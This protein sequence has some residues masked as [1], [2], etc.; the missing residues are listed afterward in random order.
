MVVFAMIIPN[1][2]FLFLFSRDIC[3]EVF[4]SDQFL[5]LKVFN[6]GFLHQFKDWIGGKNG[7]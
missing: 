2:C 4:T 6:V 3:Q 1:Y 7:T 5:L